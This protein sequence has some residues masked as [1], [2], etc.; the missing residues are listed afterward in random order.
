MKVVKIGE[1]I[2]ELAQ[3]ID[4]NKINIVPPWKKGS[5]YEQYYN[6]IKSNSMLED[7]DVAMELGYAGHKDKSFLRLQQRFENKLSYLIFTLDLGYENRNYFAT[8]LHKVVMS[9]AQGKLLMQR[10]LWQAGIFYFNKAMNIANR[11]SFPEYEYL[12]A[13]EYY[14]IFS[15]LQYNKKK[16]EYYFEMMEH[17]QKIMDA[18]LQVKQYESEL[19]GMISKKFDLKDLQKLAKGISENCQDLIQ[20]YFSYKLYI[21]AYQIIVFDFNIN[22]KLSEILNLS[23]EAKYLLNSKKLLNPGAEYIIDTSYINALITGG[24]FEEVVDLFNTLQTGITKDSHRYF[25]RENKRFTV[26]IRLNRY[27]DCIFLIDEILSSRSLSV[28]KRY[29]ELWL[30]KKGFLHLLVEMGVIETDT[31]KYSKITKYKLNKLLNQISIFSKDKAGI[32]ASLKILEMCFF[33][34]RKDEGSLIDRIDSIRQYAYKYLRND[35]NLRF[36]IFIRFLIICQEQNFNI[37]AI[38]RHTSS[39]H[40]RLIDNPQILYDSVVEAEIVPLE[41]LWEYVLTFIENNY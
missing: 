2:Y 14:K 9:Y 23:K 32:N 37:K 36:K 16:K 18:E 13:Y 6:L 3:L 30:V 38:K 19:V 39:L 5:K 31:P 40:Q 25:T 4:K 24:K 20:N 41:N 21:V 12:L 7:D 10:N 27:E 33:I 15:T 22:R 26:L 1:L 8:S 34:T 28:Y 11:I 35:E 17:Q 29:H